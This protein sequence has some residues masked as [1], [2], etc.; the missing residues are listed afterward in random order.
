GYPAVTVNTFGE[1]QAMLVVTSLFADYWTKK[2]WYLRPVT[3]KLLDLLEVRP[4]VKAQRENISL[5]LTVTRDDSQLQIHL[6]TFQEMP[7]TMKSGLIGNSP[8]V[9]GLV[10]EVAAQAIGNFDQVTL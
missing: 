10:L 3:S 8:P 7:R 4:I 1:G 5:E 9:N 6:I 2:H